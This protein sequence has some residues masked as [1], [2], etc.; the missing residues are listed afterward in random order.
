M[1]LSLLCTEKRNKISHGRQGLRYWTG[2]QRSGVLFLALHS[3]AVGACRARYR[4]GME[5]LAN[6]FLLCNFYSFIM[7]ESE[8]FQCSSVHL[9]A[10][11]TRLNQNTEPAEKENEWKTSIIKFSWAPLKY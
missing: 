9:K 2:C 4:A 11:E 8:F 3:L 1:I 10:G 7:H 6:K 5:A